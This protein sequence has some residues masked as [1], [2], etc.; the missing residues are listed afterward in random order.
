[1]DDGDAIQG[2]AVGTLTDGEALLQLMNEVGYDVAIPGNH[3][4]DYGMERFPEIV[5]E[6][7]FPYIS[8]NFR[9]EG[10]PVLAPYVVLERWGIKIGFVGVTT[11]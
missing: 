11:L 2:Q 9:K 10:K 6:A 7:D 4:F 8:C 1:M 3:E 5:E